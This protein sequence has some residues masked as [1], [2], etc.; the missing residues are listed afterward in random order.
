VI[1]GI[2]KPPIFGRQ[3]YELIGRSKIVLNGAIDMAGQDRGNMRCFE[4]M[5]CGALL[6]SDAGSY[7]EG[8]VAD[9][10][11]V[12]YETGRDCLDQIQ[13]C[14][15]DWTAAKKIA[16]SGRRQIGDLYTKERQWAL[17]NMI[18]ARL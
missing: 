7:L 11:I 15:S 18:V 10:T 5:G 12:T 9:E 4:A 2:A 1:A 16:D 3:L 14:L 17:F 8:M 13:R 6:V